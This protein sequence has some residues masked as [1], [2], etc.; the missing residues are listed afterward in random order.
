MDDKE[1]QRLKEELDAARKV[2]E[3]D[4]SVANERKLRNAQNKLLKLLK[5]LKK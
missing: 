2:Y 1:Y 5:F 4:K 3:Q